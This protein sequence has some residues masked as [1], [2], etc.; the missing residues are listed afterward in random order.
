ME[1]LV[2]T[3]GGSPQPVITAIKER[4]PL[5]DRVVFL[6]SDDLPTS[7][8]SYTDV[9]KIVAE[10]GLPP[11]RHAVERIQFIDDL[12]ECY[13]RARDALAQARAKHPDATIIANYTGGTKTMTA[14]LALAAVDDARTE[15]SLV[16]G[17]RTNRERV[18]G[19]TEYAQP[20]AVWDVRARRRLDEVG[21]ALQRY[22]YPSAAAE[23]EEMRRLPISPS[24]R[25]MVQAARD[26]CGGLDAWD[27][28]QHER[29]RR[30]LQPYRG[31][32]QGPDWRPVWAMI[33]DLCRAEPADAYLVVRDLV[34][35]AERRVAQGRYDDA[36]ARVYRSLE[37]IA[38][39]RLRR[40]YGIDTSDVDLGKVPQGAR[41]RLERQVSEED[42]R[43]KASL[44][45]AWELLTELGDGTLGEWFGQNRNRLL[46]F[47]KLRNGSILAHG[48]TPIGRDEY[49]AEGFHGIDLCRDALGRLPAGKGRRVEA[50][51]LPRSLGALIG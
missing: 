14:G 1:I 8:G 18:E 28:F 49:E 50:V 6:C 48:L 45:D 12:Q 22:D 41:S 17:T 7:K 51:Q 25:G 34:L 40:E 15:I 36:V 26:V 44:R 46:N 10:A 38:Q 47:L 31:R 20:V 21:R 9:A 3:V 42:S 35:N 32:L 30:A 19:G 39:L 27:R 37:M 13:T 43:V 33:D 16:T 23:L 4:S 24:L 29:A 11:D 2:I 5:P